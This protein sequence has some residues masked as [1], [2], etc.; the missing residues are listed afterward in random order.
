[1]N[2]D[3][4][5]LA[6]VAR[7]YEDEGYRVMVEPRGDCLPAFALG[8]DIDLI[9]TKPGE[10][11]V[12]EVKQNRSELDRDRQLTSLANLVNAQPGWG[13][14][15]VII[16][17]ETPVE[18]LLPRSQEPSTEQ[19]QQ[20]L[21]RAEQLLAG[22]ELPLAC[23]VAWAAAEATMR[24]IKLSGAI[25]GRSEPA[26][27]MRTLYAHGDVTPAEFQQLRE[28]FNHRTQAVHGL[29]TPDLD[30]SSV[31]GLIDITRRMLGSAG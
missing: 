7:C 29:L 2:F 4:A 24:A 10:A 21:A 28:A 22:D 27:L 8:L 12:V 11:V 13:F 6:H 31:R 3:L 16:D 20:M 1:M 5:P 9:A 30:E 15:L 25:A 18:K 23:I 26:E 19:I 17:P 14:D